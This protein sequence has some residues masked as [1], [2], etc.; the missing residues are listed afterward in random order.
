MLSTFPGKEVL[1]CALQVGWKHAF[2]GWGGWVEPPRWVWHRVMVA[3]AVR[4]FCHGSWPSVALPASRCDSSH[5]LGLAI[6]LQKV[7]DTCQNPSGFDYR[8]EIGSDL[9]NFKYLFHRVTS[10][11]LKG[12][13]SEPKC[14]SYDIIRHLS[15]HGYYKINNV[16]RG[17]GK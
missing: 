13:K 10:N 6:T 1:T 9:R 12:Y 14:S 7:Q 4:R 3:P 5:Q 11:M 2:Y 15:L 8:C 16:K 17:R